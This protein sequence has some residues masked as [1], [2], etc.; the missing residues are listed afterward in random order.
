MKHGEATEN[1]IEYCTNLRTNI[2]N[3]RNLFSKIFSLKLCE[4]PQLYL[5][6]KHIK[7]EYYSYT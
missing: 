2:K 3:L 6:K 5:A 1:S 4:L 7:Q